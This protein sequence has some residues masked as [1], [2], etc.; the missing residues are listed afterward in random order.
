MRADN[1]VVTYHYVR[2]SNSEG[3]TGITQQQFAQQLDMIEAAGYRFVTGEEFVQTHREQSGMALV[4]FDDAVSDQY[5][6][7]FPVLE[8]HGVPATIF[9]PMRP[10]SNESD[11]WLTQHLAHALASSLGWAELERR[12]DA[13]VGPVSVNA[14]R[15]NALYHYEAP[16]KRRLKM[17][18]AFVL[19]QATVRE[20]LTGINASEGLQAEDWFM[21]AEQL[22]E[23][24]SAGHTIGG[25]GF[26]HV[27]FGTLSPKAQAGDMHRAQQLLAVLCGSMS[28]PLAYPYGSSSPETE[29]IARGV[30]YT[31]CF[32]TAS[33]IDASVLEHHLAEAR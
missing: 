18:L 23:M 22:V 9:A 14:D 2:A 30:G 32:D 11:R 15:M 17:L 1:L 31:H 8:E 27:P 20:V 4:T 29:A 33:R 6:S 7:A 28:R 19:D 21:T 5:V 24:Q 10:Y 26:D 13:I 12:V 3:V 16:E 25:H